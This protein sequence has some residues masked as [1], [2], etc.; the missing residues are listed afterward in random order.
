ML[1]G[2][3]DDAYMNEAGNIAYIWDVVDATAGDL[4]ALFVNDKLILKEG[5]AVDLDGDGTIEPTSPQ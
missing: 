1:F 5:D 2:S 3:I 4:E